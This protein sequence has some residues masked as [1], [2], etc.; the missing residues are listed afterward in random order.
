MKEITDPK[1]GQTLIELSEEEI[2]Y[3]FLAQCI[4]AVAEAEK[5][6]YVEMLDK[7][8]KA[9]MT[10]GYILDCYEVLHTMSLENIV[11][12]I[13]NLLHKRESCMKS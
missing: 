3:G 12:D 6:D 9:D 11:S 13:V 7:L 4:E 8:E 5:C 10:E 1:S 2:K